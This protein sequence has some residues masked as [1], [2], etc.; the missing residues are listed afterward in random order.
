MELVRLKNKRLNKMAN[1]EVVNE[2]LDHL[3]AA[4]EEKSIFDYIMAAN[5]VSQNEKELFKKFGWQIQII[6]N[7]YADV[8]GTFAGGEY[9]EG[10]KLPD[11]CLEDL[12]KLHQTIQNKKETINVI[13]EAS[14][15][16]QD[17]AS[18]KKELEEK[19]MDAYQAGDKE[20]AEELKKEYNQILKDVEASRKNKRLIKKN[21]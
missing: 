14:T 15:Q 13:E 4:I 11:W 20:K 12:E 8:M 18:K 6:K 2:L 10:D 5:I 16:Y 21:K 17:K 3:Q 1:T 19:I 7:L 9:Q